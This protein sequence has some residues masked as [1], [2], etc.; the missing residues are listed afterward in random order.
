MHSLV[1]ICLIYLTAMRSEPGQRKPGHKAACV[2]VLW[3][4]L[5]STLFTC[6]NLKCHLPLSVICAVFLF[7]RW[8]E[9]EREIERDRLHALCVR[10]PCEEDPIKEGLGADS[11][12]RA[13]PQRTELHRQCPLSKD[14]RFGKWV[15]CD[16]LLWWAAKLQ[17]SC[18]I[19]SPNLCMQPHS[20]FIESG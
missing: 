10:L 15:V 11:Q 19:G 14:H 7:H 9:R 12:L 18:H 20:A 5:Y 17:Y 1:P 3:K 16:I 8:T 4:R 6:N 13:P 2:C